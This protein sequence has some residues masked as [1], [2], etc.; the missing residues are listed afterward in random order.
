MERQGEEFSSYLTMM[1]N[2]WSDTQRD[3]GKRGLVRG[4][5]RN[6]AKSQAEY[7]IVQG[8]MVSCVQTNPL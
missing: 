4:S 6:F 7:R 2:D 5:K 1:S 3:P 8:V